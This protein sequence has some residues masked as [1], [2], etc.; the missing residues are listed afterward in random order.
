MYEHWSHHTN[1]GPEDIENLHPETLVTLPIS[2]QC[3]AESKFMHILPSVSKMLLHTS[4]Q[5]VRV[6]IKVVEY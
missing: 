1:F 5:N 4:R 2:T 3:N 6:L